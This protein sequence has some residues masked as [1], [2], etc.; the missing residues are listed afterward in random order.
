MILKTIS[1]AAIQM[2]LTA[3]GLS[4]QI[5]N[6]LQ[7]LDENYL[8]AVL[9]KD[10]KSLDSLMSPE[11]WWVSPGG[12]MVGKQERL[13]S[14]VSRQNPIISLV[15]K[16]RLITKIGAV[17]RVAGVYEVR[18]VVGGKEL[19]APIRFVRLYQKLNDRWQLVTEQ[20]VQLGMET[21]QK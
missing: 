16:E 10:N 5:Q 7:R 14:I 9:K 15:T 18:G 12:E 8:A 2:T 19:F 21:A 13:S 1:L 17:Y 20:E 6:E 11:F 4:P 3:Q